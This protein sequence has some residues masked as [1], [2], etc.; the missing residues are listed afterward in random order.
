MIGTKRHKSYWMAQQTGRLALL[1]IVLLCLGCSSHDDDTQPADALPNAVP[2]GSKQPALSLSVYVYAS[3]QSIPTRGDVGNVDPVSSEI[4]VS[5]LQIWVFTHDSGELVGYLNPSADE[6]NSRQSATYLMTVSE[7]F[8]DTHPNVDVYVL[9]NTSGTYTELQANST[10][11]SLE[12]AILRNGS[13]DPFASTACTTT[14]PASGLPMSGVLRDQPVYG[15]NPV[16]HIGSLQ[17]ISTVILT[18]MVSKVYFLFSRYESSDDNFAVSSIT[19]HGNTIPKEEYLFLGNDG[20][21]YHVG[22]TYEQEAARLATNIGTTAACEDPTLYQYRDGIDAQYYEDLLLSAVPDKLTL[23]GPFYMRE[24]DRRLSGTI[25]YTVNGDERQTDFV[26]ARAG[27][28]AR[29]HTWM[30]YSYYAGA[31]SNVLVVNG[32]FVKEWQEV[33][34][35]HK[36]HNW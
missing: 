9:A 15:D 13:N 5:S 31:G 35:E 29:N 32:I 36:L 25:G 27:D 30:V 4:R 20:M 2:E 33:E 6:L 22:Y 21:N 12:A 8:A 7:T 24:S 16:L 28:F 18:R 3:D 10:K 34:K 23:V 11:A 17:E 14:V 19:L 1:A 26:M